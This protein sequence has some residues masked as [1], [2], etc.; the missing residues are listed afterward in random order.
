V[1]L[2]GQVFAAPGVESRDS[3]FVRPV[4]DAENKDAQ[5]CGLY[6]FEYFSFYE[7]MKRA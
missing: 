3:G 5:G 4:I 7:P 6:A 1:A 2:R